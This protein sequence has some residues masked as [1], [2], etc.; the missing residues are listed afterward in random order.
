MGRT[1]F[2]I[3]LAMFLL[4]LLFGWLTPYVLPVLPDYGAHRFAYG[5]SG[6]LLLL[7]SLLMLGGDFWD[8][9]RALFVRDAKVQ[10]SDRGP[11]AGLGG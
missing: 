11:V 9:L 1:R 5:V 6:D 3:G 10:F 4:P 2:R 7:A 8:K